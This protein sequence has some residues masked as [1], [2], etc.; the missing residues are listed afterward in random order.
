[1]A[2]KKTDNVDI[3]DLREAAAYLRSRAFE[4]KKGC[5]PVVYQEEL[6]MVLEVLE[7]GAFK[8]WKAAMQIVLPEF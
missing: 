5:P 8:E 1:M 7:T 3:D 4:M 6:E 2:K